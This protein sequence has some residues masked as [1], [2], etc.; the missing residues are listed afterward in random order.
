M[1][2]K[3]KSGFAKL[4]SDYIAYKGLSQVRLSELRGIPVDTIKS[5]C[6]GRRSPNAYDMNLVFGSDEDWLIKARNLKLQNQEQKDLTP[7]SSANSVTDS[8][9][10][11]CE[12]T[13]DI[14]LVNV[15]VA[16]LDER[17]KK[18]L[19]E[20]I[21]SGRTLFYL[22]ETIKY[23]SETAKNSLLNA[24]GFTEEEIAYHEYCLEEID[25]IAKP[26]CMGVKFWEDVI[27]LSTEYEFSKY[28]TVENNIQVLETLP[29][30]LFVKFINHFLFLK[31]GHYAQCYID[32]PAVFTGDL[33]CHDPW[34]LT[35]DSLY[36]IC[37]MAAGGNVAIAEWESVN[38]G[39]GVDK[40]IFDNAPSGFCNWSYFE[41]DA[42]HDNYYPPC[43]EKILSTLLYSNIL[44][45][46][47]RTR[48]ADLRNI[49]ESIY[50][51]L[52]GDVEIR[53]YQKIISITDAG[54][55]FLNWYEKFVKET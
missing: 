4:L 1:V 8:E 54:K 40:V 20:V 49:R 48:K 34:T 43:Y 3:E 26:V 2:K 10:K 46:G 45:T 6:S 13:C 55:A 22:R 42:D 37:S 25:R 47:A 53:I 51:F 5:W 24:Y 17:D 18:F 11:V 29:K 15:P 28:S 14:R 41:M 12:N 21:P 30:F 9:K 36:K 7:E 52:N 27:K 35:L 50:R 32:N 33:M 31:G 19:K 38:E 23:D 39:V 16:I 44:Q